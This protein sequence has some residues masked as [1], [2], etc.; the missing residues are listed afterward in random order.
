MGTLAGGWVPG[1]QRHGQTNP[2]VPQDTK[3]NTIVIPQEELAATDLDKSDILFYTL[4]EVTPVSTP[5]SLPS[6]LPPGRP[7]PP[8]ASQGL[9]ST[10]LRVPGASSPWWA[11][12]SLPCGWTSPWTST[13]ART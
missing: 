10:P 2:S 7:R 4:Q 6:S 5:P 8:T 13:G 1:G 3:V 11:Q 12:T 9:S